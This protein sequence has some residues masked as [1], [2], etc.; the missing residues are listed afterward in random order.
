M[1]WVYDSSPEHL[2]SDSLVRN[3][4]AKTKI[5]GLESLY[6]QVLEY[7]WILLA[8]VSRDFVTLQIQLRCR[9]TP[10]ICTC[11]FVLFKSQ[12]FKQLFTALHSIFL[13]S[14]FFNQNTHVNHS[15]SHSILHDSYTR[16]LR[17]HKLR[18]SCIH[19]FL[20]IRH[21]VCPNHSLEEDYKSD[22]DKFSARLNYQ[23][24]INIFLTLISI[25]TLI[26]QRPCPTRGLIAVTWPIH[27]IA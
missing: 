19:K 4:N 12:R 20:G 8:L 17:D 27:V 3:L 9:F 18:Y 10:S 22:L 1:F 6:K 13:D 26:T 23:V 7:P 24:W 5:Q 16:L 21:H 11:L 14:S 15:R 2:V 25:F